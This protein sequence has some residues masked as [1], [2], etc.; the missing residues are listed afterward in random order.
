MI[1]DTKW[2]C[3]NCG[4]VNSEVNFC[5]NCGKERKIITTKIVATQRG[6]RIC[7]RIAPKRAESTEKQYL[8]FF[9]QE[10]SSVISDYF[11][12]SVYVFP[13]PSSCLK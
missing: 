13:D 10:K 7:T 2:K 9:S 4:N 8:C 1:N 6:F 5:I 11:R 3:D 12:G